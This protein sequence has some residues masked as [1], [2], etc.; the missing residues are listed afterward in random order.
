MKYLPTI[1]LP[2][3]LALLGVLPLALLAL[4]S[5]AV[6]ST[7]RAQD[8]K[9]EITPVVKPE[10]DKAHDPKAPPEKLILPSSGADDPHEQMEKLFGE[11][12][13]KMLRVNR[14]LQEASA[15]KPRAQ[16]SGELHETIETIEKL[17]QE[18]TDSSRSAVEDIDKILELANHEHSGGT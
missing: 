9:P 16:A 12:E 3:A 5:S 11:V 10:A 8:A 17:L 6:A 18:T 4:S 14:L 2:R 15:G 1:R 13:R 7:A